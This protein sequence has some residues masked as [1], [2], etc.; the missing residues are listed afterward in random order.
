M[1]S[2]LTVYFSSFL[3]QH[4]NNWTKWNTSI[5]LYPQLSGVVFLGLCWIKS[6][7]CP[8]RSLQYPNTIA[9][10]YTTT[11]LTISSLL[12]WNYTM[13]CKYKSVLYQSVCALD[14][15]M[16]SS[17]AIT[18]TFPLHFC[19]QKN[20]LCIMLLCGFDTLRHC[21]WVGNIHLYKHHHYLCYLSTLIG[22]YRSYVSEHWMPTFV[23]MYSTCVCATIFFTSITHLK[24]LRNYRQI[25]WYLP[26]LWHIHAAICQHTSIELAYH[27]HNTTVQEP[28]EEKT[29]LHKST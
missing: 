11:G 25:P 3:H 1:K 24:T 9:N 23:R 22:W 10:K 20:A 8:K 19:T 21:M 7:L 2:D 6:T 12:F 13:H 5:S 4:R 14:Y 18:S 27:H 28:I 16:I 26:W 15:A 29:H 17:T